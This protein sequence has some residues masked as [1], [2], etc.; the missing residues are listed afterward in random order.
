MKAVL[1]CSLA[2]LVLMFLGQS[3]R[4]AFSS[5]YVFADSL[6]STTNNVNGG[7]NY[8]G[9]RWCNGPV[10][11][12]YLARDQGIAYRDSNN[13]SGFGFNTTYLTNFVGALAVLPNASNSLFV[14]WAGASDLFWDWVYNNTHDAPWVA[15]INDH[16]ANTAWIIQDLYS[17]GARSLVLPNAVDIGAAPMFAAL[18][19]ASKTYLHQ[20]AIQYNTALS[21][22]VS[23]IH[24]T[25]PALAI[26]SPD[27]FTQLQ[28]LLAN[29][30]AYGLA[31]TTIDA[32]DDP[33]LIDKSTNGPGANYI[34]WDTL[35]PTTKVQ[36]LIAEQSLLLMSPRI[37]SFTHA[38]ASNRLDVAN[39]PVGAAF[40][41]ETSTNLIIWRTNL[42]LTATNVLQTIDLQTNA[43]RLFF[44][45]KF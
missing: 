15:S 6:S 30:T 24:V 18:P 1:K 27:L 22:L 19:A 5:M 41:L 40:S 25:L 17:K 14:V 3:T 23:Q 13:V 29:P 36:S 42:S 45:L 44:R 37:S 10:W 7:T 39:L 4:G 2:V 35:H 26:Y 12:E 9:T 28:T 43:N 33:T 21:N 31:N 32:L 34:F 16:M 20:K 38:G 8:F 11:V